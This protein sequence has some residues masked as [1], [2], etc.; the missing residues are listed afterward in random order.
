[1]SAKSWASLVAIT[2][3]F[4]F[5]SIATAQPTNATPKPLATPQSPTASITSPGPE[6]KIKT[7]TSNIPTTS[8][9]DHL[10]APSH[11]THT[12]HIPE[13]TPSIAV[14]QQPDSASSQPEPSVSPTQPNEAAKDAQQ[15]D[16]TSILNDEPEQQ[17]SESQINTANPNQLESG[18]T[19]QTISQP[20][21]PQPPVLSV[22]QSL[23]IASPPI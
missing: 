21:N 22:D 17:S 1:M 15:V 6:N 9:S 5:G 13:T 11:S 10:R 20:N 19:I 16:S 23:H 18:E 3:V 7:A 8:H 2:L 4:V 14:P 12:E